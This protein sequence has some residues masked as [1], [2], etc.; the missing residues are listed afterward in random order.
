MAF[1]IILEIYYGSSLKYFSTNKEARDGFAGI[2]KLKEAKDSER[3][4]KGFSNLF[5][6]KIVEII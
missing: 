2:E 5:L 3:V 6:L 4:K 1:R